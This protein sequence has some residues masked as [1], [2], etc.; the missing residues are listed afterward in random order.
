MLLKESKQI[1]K[2]PGALNPSLLSAV[3]LSLP[4]K[5]DTIRSGLGNSYL[6]L[7]LALD[8]SVRQAKIGQVVILISS[9]RQ[10]RLS[11][12]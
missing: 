8:A 11:F 9:K 3:C 2:L 6:V 4:G 10:A 7:Y 12:M 1:S 5:T